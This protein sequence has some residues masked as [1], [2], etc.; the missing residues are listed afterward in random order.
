VLHLLHQVAGTTC[1]SVY[2][3]QLGQDNE[4]A[5]QSGAFWFYRKLGFRPGR[6]DLRALTEAEEKKIARQP[7]HRTSARTLR[8]LAAG[9]VF[10]EF[11]NA[12][13]GL[14]DNFSTRNIQLLAQKRMALYFDGNLTAMRKETTAALGRA[15]NVRLTQWSESERMAFSDFA[16]IASMLSGVADW[17]G[18][19]KSG[20]ADVIRAKAAPEEARYLRLTQQH[21]ALKQA[22]VRL[23]SSPLAVE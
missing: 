9:H 7:K 15:L 16:I 8:K 14:Y 10:Y 5:I 22:V 13:R 20:L 1:F 6:P 17:N 21:Q 19:A 18:D 23:G 4:E 11:A 3:Y 2:P 12:P